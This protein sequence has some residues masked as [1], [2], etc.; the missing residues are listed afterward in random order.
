VE[1]VQIWIAAAEISSGVVF[2]SVARG[3][4]LGAGLNPE[5]AARIIKEDSALPSRRA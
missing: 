5:S 1:A 2:R 4:R 3:G